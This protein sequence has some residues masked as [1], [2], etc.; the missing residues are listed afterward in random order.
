MLVYLC[1]SLYSSLTLLPS[2]D[3]SEKRLRLSSKAVI[4]NDIENMTVDNL[5]CIVGFPNISKFASVIDP[6]VSRE[7]VKAFLEHLKQSE[8][9]GRG[10]RHPNYANVM[11]NSIMTQQMAMPMSSFNNDGPDDD[12]PEET[13][14]DDLHLYDFKN[15]F[16]QKKERLM[17]PI[18]EI[19]IPYKDVYHCKINA[20]QSGGIYSGY[21]EQDK[22]EDVL[23]K[24]NVYY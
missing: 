20:L 1:I 14:V 22:F 21:E 12:P 17:L 8:V 9:T 23:P 19:E 2:K 15:I 16:L 18:F 11:S 24:L 10:H 13:N 6:M 5:F 3:P 7:D 4:L